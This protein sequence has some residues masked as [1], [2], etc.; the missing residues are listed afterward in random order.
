MSYGW[1]EIWRVIRAQVGVRLSR[2]NR[3][4]YQTRRNPGLLASD[5]LCGVHFLALNKGAQ[6][7]CGRNG[8]RCLGVSVS[9]LTRPTG[10]NVTSPVKKKNL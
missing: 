8:I 5:V 6:P 3:Q 2:G 10:K 1:G 7:S 4:A 9:L